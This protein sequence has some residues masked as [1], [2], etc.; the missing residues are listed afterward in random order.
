MTL[1]I[2]SVFHNDPVTKNILS[3]SYFNGQELVCERE[4][5]ES[6]IAWHWKS[7]FCGNEECKCSINLL[8]KDLESW[9]WK[10]V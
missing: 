10:T 6:D 2:Y 9:F 8:K 3:Y 7:D 1:V 5:E 4:K